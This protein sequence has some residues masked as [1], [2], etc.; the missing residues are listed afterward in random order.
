MFKKKFL[1]QD[2]LL[3]IDHWLMILDFQGKRSQQKTEA[4]TQPPG[5]PPI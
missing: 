4:R 2:L 1:V 3:V 5:T